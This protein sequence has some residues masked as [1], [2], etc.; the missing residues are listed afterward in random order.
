[1]KHIVKYI[2]LEPLGVSHPHLR[3][4]EHPPVSGRVPDK[5]P[6]LTF[7]V[8]EIERSVNMVWDIISKP[9]DMY[10]RSIFSSVGDREDC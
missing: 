10:P 7:T 4:Q 3:S 8:L 5:C 2:T 1:M 6:D 9:L